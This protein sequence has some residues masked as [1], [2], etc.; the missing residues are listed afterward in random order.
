MSLVK[1]HPAPLGAFIGTSLM[2][3]LYL[4]DGIPKY[5][6]GDDF[7]LLNSSRSTGGYASSIVGCVND[8]GMGKWRPMFVCTVT[9]LLKL[10][11]DNYLCYFVLNLVLLFLVCVVATNL[12]R[13]VFE[14]SGWQIA[15]IAFVMPFSRFTWYGR[16]SPFGLMEFGALLF[17]LLFLRQC[18][19]ALSRQ[20]Q[21]S[22][23]LAGALA[24]LSTF[25]HERYLV[26]LAAGFMVAMFNLRNKLA[27]VPLSPWIMYLGF[28]LAI[29][30]FF[31]RV[32][33]LV[34]GGEVAIRSSADTWILEHFLV[35]TKAVMGLGNGTNID[36]DR[37]G[38]VRMPELGVL[39]IAW[40]V[41]MLLI[42]LSVLRFRT[43]VGKKIH[44]SVSKVP[45]ELRVQMSVIQQLT[46]IS[47]LLLIIPAST[48]ISRIEGR[49]LLGPEV[50]VFIFILS[51]LKSQAWRTLFISSYL[52]FSVACLNFIS[53]Y[54]EPI[55]SSNEIFDYVHGKLNGKTE[56][57]YTI[58]DPRNHFQQLEWQLGY[59]NKFKQLG[60]TTSV[61]VEDS[62]CLEP[63]IRI[64]LKDKRRIELDTRP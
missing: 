64:V 48:I 30:V 19:S 43:S 22:W 5:F 14:I 51:M 61:F 17:A 49:W 41:T 40:L 10:F 12:L 15:L 33:P 1:R 58:V 18:L 46:L 6:F 38:Y 4:M 63:C 59:N 36:F 8:I 26:L 31:L 39:G 23:Y 37:S 42:A 24:C 11:G 50:F 60:V 62:K 54:E 2:G 16:V 21:G 7:L 13:T 44:D 20:T 53:N 25:F 3:L 55:R 32:D 34:G 56:M 52:I 9:P 28:Y 57:S 27:K 29:K 47:G 45:R 35:G